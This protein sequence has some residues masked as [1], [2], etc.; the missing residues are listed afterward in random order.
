VA[1]IALLVK[2]IESGRGELLAI[3]MEDKIHQPYRQSLIK[4]YESVKIA[5]IAA[6]AYNLV[7][8][9]AG[10]TVLAITHP[11]QS[12]DVQNAIAT[13]W[14]KEGINAIVSALQIDSQGARITS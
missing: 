9:G 13:A 10:P 8:S 1:H 6:G 5:A 2:A 14:Q 11:E 12:L 3:A 7:I 4:G